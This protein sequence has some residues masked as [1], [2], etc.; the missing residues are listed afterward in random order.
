MEKRK[1]VS[2]SNCRKAR[3][4]HN[5]WEDNMKIQQKRKEQEQ[6]NE[7]KVKDNQR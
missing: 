2:K 6:K 3:K 5:K 7:V 4:K 1:R